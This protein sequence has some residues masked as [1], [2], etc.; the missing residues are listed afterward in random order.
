VLLISIDG[1]HQVDLERFVRQ[2]P[3]STLGQLSR[4][5][6][7]YTQA[8]TSIPS[9]SFPG[10][11]AMVTGGSPAST[12]VWY[13]D[14]Y[15]RELQ[16]ASGKKGVRALFDESLSKDPSKLDGGGG[17]NPSTL[18]VDPKTGQRIFPHN[19]LRVNTIFEVAKSHGIR[20][21]WTDKHLAYDLLS[22]PSG[23]GVDD[24]YNLEI[25]KGQKG[26]LDTE[27]Y[28]DLKLQTVL[29]E[30]Q[31]KD[32][33]GEH[34]P[35]VPGLFG[36]NIQ[37]VS[38]AQKLKADPRDKNLK[39]GYQDGSATP[40]T[41]LE[42]ALE[43]TDG[44]LGR[45]VNELRAQ[46]LWDS[47]LLIITSKHGQSPIDPRS[48]VRVD[49][50][51]IP[52]IVNSIQPGLLAHAIQ[53]TMP[54]LWLKDRSKTEAVAQALAK[55]D[56]PGGIL[57]VLWGDTLKKRFQCSLEDS[58]TPDLIVIPKPG[59][60]FAPKGA[61]KIAEHGGASAD[62][63]WVGL[64]VS[65]P[66]LPQRMF[67]Q[68]VRTAQIAPTIMAVLGLDPHELEAVKIEHTPVLPGF[69]K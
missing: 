69:L 24:L 40:S 47:T 28:D 15:D 53:D 11:T 49:E 51:L 46:G 36:M 31:G 67:S 58:R 60:V 66:Q 55:A 14:S 4:H 63:T 17:I 20:T 25:G 6:F 57:E 42:H 54:I 34:R 30:I 33:S 39:G 43:H 50:G 18:P 37:A 41:G 61:K 44:A 5:G 52:G 3:D 48:L 13:D 64:L 8:S 65:N 2:R 26:I 1:L 45:I 29:H 62:D 56:I 9:D 27:A 12:G 59:A 19:Y 7:T 35:G 68:A 21:A 22:G 32:H 10:L 23:K 16:S 38:V